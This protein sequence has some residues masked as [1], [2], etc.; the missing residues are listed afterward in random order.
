MSI[1][2]LSHEPVA[3]PLGNAEVAERP[4]DLAQLLSAHDECGVC[5]PACRFRLAF[6]A[7]ASVGPEFCI[8]GGWVFSEAMTVAKKANGRA[9]CSAE[10]DAGGK[11]SVT[12]R[13]AVERIRT[14]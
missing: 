14:L 4:D 7:D 8:T 10:Q 11:E 12:N 6:R 3:M 13:R 9:V 5:S 1:E 2:G